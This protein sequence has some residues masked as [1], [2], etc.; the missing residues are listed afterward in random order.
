[1]YG[2]YKRPGTRFSEDGET[3]FVRLRVHRHHYALAC[4]WAESCAGRHAG[5]LPE[6]YLES[7]LEIAILTQLTT[8]RWGASPAIEA[9][10][11]ELDQA[12]DPEE[13]D[14]SLNESEEEN[15]F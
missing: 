8:L 7:L 3:A 14:H 9:Y 15:P 1:M 12:V 5:K 6:D 11:V 2:T 10:F 13:P 4:A